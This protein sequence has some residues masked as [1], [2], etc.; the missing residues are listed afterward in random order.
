MCESCRIQSCLKKCKGGVDRTTIAALGHVPIPRFLSLAGLFTKEDR[1]VVKG[2][3][4]REIIVWIGI[5]NGRARG[6]L[7]FALGAH[8]FNPVVFPSRNFCRYDSTSPCR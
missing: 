6:H 5:E 3:W 7:W 1:I 2:G 4:Q 8:C